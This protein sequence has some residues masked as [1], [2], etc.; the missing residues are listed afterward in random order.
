[1]AEGCDGAA[2]G[3]LAQAAL[4]MNATCCR[5]GCSL[6]VRPPSFPMLGLQFL[7]ATRIEEH[8]MSTMYRARAVV[9]AAFV[10]AFAAP[11][12]ANAQAIIKV[13]D[14]VSVRI[15]FLS[16]TWADFTQN[17]RQDSSY[18]QQ[19]FQ[20]RI[21][22][23]VSA[24]LGPKV[25]FFFETDNP[26]L[27]RTGPNPLGGNFT[28]ALGLGFLTQD[29]Y[30]ELKPSTTNSFVIEAGLLL[31]PLCRNCVA[32]AAAL[33]PL[34]Y[35]DYSFLQSGPTAS[36]A[37][38]D[39]GLEGKG[40][41]LNQRLEY[42]LGVFSGARLPVVPVPPAVQTASNSLRGAG[43]LMFNFLETEPPAYGM[44]GTYF[45]RRKVFNIGAGGDLQS[46][47][48]A[49]AGDAFLSYPFGNNGIT[50]SGTFI[51]FDGGTFLPTL[52]RQNTW[53]AEGGYHFTAA[54]LTPWAKFETRS[55]D[56]AFV[57]AA[58]QDEHR[59][60]LGLTYYMMGHNLNLKAAYSRNTFDQLAPLPE[61]HQNAFTMQ[62]QGYYY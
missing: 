61:L 13:N 2:S 19:I 48:K 27:G 8:A 49:I 7:L 45:G 28:K 37:G 35:S 3:A 53:E 18:A 59:L 33:L 24:Q 30:V 46:K 56:D 15:G 38:R 1:M 44:P 22:L 6:A 39:M 52:P 5:T 40:T 42:R 20:R 50:L 25:A 12:T 21:R 57:T 55:I 26:N 36:S 54:K 41:L 47:Y 34:D 11:L 29:V 10:V 58:N 62:L 43:H 23:I 16:Q 9:L 4:R 14:S 32:S 31:I 60:Q 51:H 17:V